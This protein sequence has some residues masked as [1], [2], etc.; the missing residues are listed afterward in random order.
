MC[1]GS[2]L[3]RC[4]PTISDKGIWEPA[5][6]RSLRSEVQF[7]NGPERGRNRPQEAG[8]VSGSHTSRY[9]FI[10]LRP[11]DRRREKMPL[12]L[13][14]AHCYAI[15]IDHCMCVH[16]PPNKSRERHKTATAGELWNRRM[17]PVFLNAVLWKRRD[18]IS[19][20][21]TPWRCLNTT[22]FKSINV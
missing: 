6:S 2:S 13:L 10:H 9:C 8:R 7:S 14:G 3:G 15:S 12:S 11:I 4:H 18:V 17:L 19:T 1:F 16:S 21:P 22:G 20:F 5:F